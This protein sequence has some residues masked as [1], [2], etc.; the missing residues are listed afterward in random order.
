ME[1]GQQ[2]PQKETLRD[3]KTGSLRKE[4]YEKKL[5]LSASRPRGDAAGQRAALEE[6]Q[7]LPTQRGRSAGIV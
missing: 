5:P 4:A 2:L 6:P 3:H 7:V 1:R